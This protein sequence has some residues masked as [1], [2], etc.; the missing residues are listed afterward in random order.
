MGIWIVLTL[1]TVLAGGFV[2]AL[3]SAAARPMAR[4][5]RGFDDALK[6]C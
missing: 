2:L 4:E 1:W 5:K 3:C 6:G